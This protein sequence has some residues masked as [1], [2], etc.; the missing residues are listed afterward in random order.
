[1]LGNVYSAPSPSQPWSFDVLKADIRASG[2]R[3][4]DISVRSNG[5]FVSL[6]LRGA[7]KTEEAC[8][9]AMSFYTIFFDFSTSPDGQASKS[10]ATGS[11][12]LD[13]CTLAESLPSDQ[14]TREVR[15]LILRLLQAGLLYTQL[16][17]ELFAAEFKECQTEAF[18]RFSRVYGDELINS[19]YA[20]LEALDPRVV[21]AAVRDYLA[22]VPDGI[23][24]RL[25]YDEVGVLVDERT[26]PGG[27]RFSPRRFPSSK[28]AA[29]DIG[30]GSLTASSLDLEADSE[31]TDKHPAAVPLAPTAPS[32]PTTT[33]TRTAPRRTVFHIFADVVC[34]VRNWQIPQ[35]TCPCPGFFRCHCLDC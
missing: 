4:R 15:P 27:K 32:T 34:E 21:D 6:Q 23:R 2:Q 31:R 3:M 7:G 13:I 26:A 18:F 8:W 24:P 20:W 19:I 5:V 22:R 33:H 11:L 1:M 25:V 30:S 35:G 12:F 16:W 10:A 9:A 17:Q 28:T 14:L 29:S